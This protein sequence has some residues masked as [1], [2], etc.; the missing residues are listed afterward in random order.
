MNLLNRIYWRLTER[1]FEEGMRSGEM[2]GAYYERHRIIKALEDADSACAPW[3][4][5]VIKETK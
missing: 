1:I 2:L 3:A 4:V 5:A